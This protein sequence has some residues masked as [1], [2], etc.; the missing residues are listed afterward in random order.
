VLS[1]DNTNDAWQRNAGKG[2]ARRGLAWQGAA[3]QGK[4]FT[5]LAIGNSRFPSATA[6]RQV[7]LPD[8]HWQIK[9]RTA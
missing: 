1:G 4:G 6:R 5:G 2:A 8:E 9:T 3:K 7:A